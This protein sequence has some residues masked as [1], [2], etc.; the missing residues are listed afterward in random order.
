M[1]NITFP[2]LFLKLHAGRNIVKLEGVYESHFSLDH[3]VSAGIQ[4]LQR[5]LVIKVV[6][7]SGTIKIIL[8]HF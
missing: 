3:D 5:L 6:M 1:F 2:V 7:I 8:T 4:A